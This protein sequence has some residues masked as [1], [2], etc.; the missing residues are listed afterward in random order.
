MF[1]PLEGRIVTM[2]RTVREKA[3]G[4]LARAVSDYSGNEKKIADSLMEEL[5]VHSLIL[6]KASPELIE[7]QAGL[8]SSSELGWFVAKETS[9]TLH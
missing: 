2:T 9:Q 8:K 5:R 3:I 1:N 7:D 6:D 4:L